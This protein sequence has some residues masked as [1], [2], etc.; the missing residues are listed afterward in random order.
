MAKQPP[1]P[2]MPSSQASGRN[3][4][5]DSTAGLLSRLMGEVSTLFRKEIALAKAE[6][7]EAASNA[8]TGAISLVA[9][10]LVL[11]AGLLVLLASAVFLLGKIVDLWLAALIVGAVVAI[12]GFALLQNGKKKLDPAAFKPERTTDALR[13]DKDMVQRRVS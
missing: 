2:S 11:F 9:A 6:I 8:K 7:T 5:A 12:I 10:G 3:H 13:K 1:S 4:E